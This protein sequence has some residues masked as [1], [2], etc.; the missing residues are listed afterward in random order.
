ML[1]EQAMDIERFKDRGRRMDDEICQALGKALGYPWFKD[2]QKNFPG[3][4]EANGVCVGDHVSES[5][6]AEAAKRI[7]EQAEQLESI[8]A[9]FGLHPEYE[10]NRLMEFIESTRHE[11]RDYCNVSAKCAEQA[12]EIG[13][14]KADL[15]R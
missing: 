1:K 7:E 15:N 9:A 6:A 10:H 8:R 13:Q 2:D 3:T 12:K 11:A 5:I 4:T 14:L